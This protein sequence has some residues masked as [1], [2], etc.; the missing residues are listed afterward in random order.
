LE[1]HIQGLGLTVKM[2]MRKGRYQVQNAEELHAL[3]YPCMVMNN[4]ITQRT[5]ELYFETWSYC[6]SEHEAYGHL[7]F[8]IVYYL[9][10]VCSVTLLVSH[11]ILH[12]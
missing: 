7:S 4:L 11:T 8:D 10:M 9:F 2:Y 3:Q 1:L 6:G 5:E 12:Q